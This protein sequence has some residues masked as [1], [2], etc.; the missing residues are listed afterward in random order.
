MATALDVKRVINGREGRVYVGATFLGWVQSIEARVVIDRQDIVRSGSHT[1]G[2]KPIGSTGTGTLNGFHVT[3][4]WRKMVS[5]Y[6]INAKM[7]EPASIT[8]ELSDPDQ[9][10]ITGATG[11]KTAQVEK[12]TLNDVYF[13]EA[14]LGFDTGD[15]VKDDIPFTFESVTWVQSIVGDADTDPITITRAGV[16]VDGTVSAAAQTPTT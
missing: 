2:Y 8:I 11:A 16:A 12:I 6:T 15:T 9:F 10:P 3:S 4:Y 14:P 7:P 13:W 1:T 5:D